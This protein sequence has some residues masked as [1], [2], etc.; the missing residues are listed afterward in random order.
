MPGEFRTTDYTLGEITD[1]LSEDFLTWVGWNKLDYKTQDYQQS[2]QF[3]WN[4][5][6]AS[7]KLTANQPLAVGAWRGLYNYFYDT[8]YPN[9]RPWEM[10]GFSVI[11]VWWEDEYGPAPYTSGNLVLWEDLAAGLVRDP[12]APYVLPE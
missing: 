2:N 3:T 8:I 6:T 9:T 7:N 10:L 4:Y 5:S 12:V 11:P 1:I